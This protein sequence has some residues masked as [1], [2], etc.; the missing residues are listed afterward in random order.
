MTTCLAVEF[1]QSTSLIGLGNL[2]GFFV[3]SNFS[4]KK[5]NQ[6]SGVFSPSEN[7]FNIIQKSRSLTKIDLIHKITWDSFWIE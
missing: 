3:W 5:Q 6:L 1:K 2:W 7:T 4:S